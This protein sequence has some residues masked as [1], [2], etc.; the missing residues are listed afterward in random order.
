MGIV[1][2]LRAYLSKW[3][4]AR[5]LQALGIYGA[6]WAIDVRRCWKEDGAIILDIGANIGKATAKL[7]K[8]FPNSKVH[9][10]EPI[11]S[12]RETLI[13]SVFGFSN[14]VV[15]G[16]ALGSSNSVELMTAE[17]NSQVNR[18]V[19]SVCEATRKHERVEVTTV[20]GFLAE[21]G[22]PHV[23]LMKIDTEGFD[24]DV[25][26]GSAHAIESGNIDLIVVECTFNPRGAPHVDVIEV[27]SFM[28]AAKYEVVAV[29][30]SNVGVFVRGSGYSDILFAR[31]RQL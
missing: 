6:D 15:H 14:V 26:R 2:K 17:D 29:Y 19:S 31:S 13:A 10:F 3:F 24:M 16:K 25:L 8:L 20:D 22:N 30:S 7:A 9:A 21:I 27:V 23:G 11:Q 4:K 12:T 28:R 5:F 1:M 18:I